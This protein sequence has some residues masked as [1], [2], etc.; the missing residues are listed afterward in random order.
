MSRRVSLGI[1]A[2]HSLGMFLAATF[3]EALSLQAL[4]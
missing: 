4:P 3:K 1:C 2:V